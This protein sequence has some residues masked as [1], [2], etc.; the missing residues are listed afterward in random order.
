VNLRSTERKVECILKEFPMT[1]FQ[2]FL[3]EHGS[4]FAAT[5]EPP[6]LVL[7]PAQGGD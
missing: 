6:S 2:Q 3:A 7:A 4:E 5:S 1:T